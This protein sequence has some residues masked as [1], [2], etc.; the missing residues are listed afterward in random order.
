MV[1]SYRLGII[2]Q[3][4]A[5]MV[6]NR[7]NS[8]IAPSVIGGLQ[9]ASFGDKRCRNRGFFKLLDLEGKKGRIKGFSQEGYVRMR[10]KIR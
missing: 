6:L 3:Q 1:K 8:A 4:A 2:S 5:A 10:I 9:M 7:I